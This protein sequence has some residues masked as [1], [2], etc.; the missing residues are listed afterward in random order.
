M[1]EV[2]AEGLGLDCNPFILDTEKKQNKKTNC[3]VVDPRC[4]RNTHTTFCYTHS[5]ETDFAS[6]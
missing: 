4:D 2:S 6:S 3:A 5:G 1:G